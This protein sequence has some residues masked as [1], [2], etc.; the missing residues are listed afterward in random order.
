[1]ALKRGGKS[2]YIREVLRDY[3]KICKK[4]PE[5]RTINEQH[6]KKS[7]LI[8]CIRTL[9]HNYDVAVG[10]LN[11]QAENIKNCVPVIR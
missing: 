2:S 9:E 5:K 7:E 8:H 11:Q 4:I 3:P 6:M 10:F 1:M